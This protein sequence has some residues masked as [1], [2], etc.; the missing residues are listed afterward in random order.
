ML[1]SVLGL[2]LMFFL[3][4]FLLQRLLFGRQNLGERMALSVGFSI[5]VSILTGL[6]LS[7]L[8][9]LTQTNTLL[10]LG[11]ISIVLYATAKRKARGKETTS[12]VNTYDLAK[13]AVVAG[14]LAFIFMLV[15][16]VHYGYTG[17]YQ[18]PHRM[19]NYIE[20]VD[21]QY[22]FPLHADEWTH[23]AQAIDTIENR[24]VSFKNPYFSQDFNYTQTG[25]L[26]PGFHVF[27]A[28]F[29]VLSGVDRVFGYQYLP[30][31]FA[32]ISALMLFMLAR[33]LSG[34]F[35][36]GIFSML[37]YA[38]LRSNVNIMGLWFFI[39]F[40]LNITV[41]YLFYYCLVS[42]LE[43]RKW[44]VALFLVTLTGFSIHASFMLMTIAIAFIYVTVV[45]R[46]FI[47][48]NKK[49]ALLL[50]VPVVLFFLGVFALKNMNLPE[51]LDYL[52]ERITFR[53]YNKIYNVHYSL[54]EFYG[55]AATILAFWGIIRSLKERRNT[56]LVIWAVLGLALWGLFAITDLNFVIRHQRQ[57]YFTL[58]GL[59]PLSAIG[60]HHI[61]SWIKEKAGKT[62]KL[63]GK[64]IPNTTALL[65]AAAVFYATF[66]GYYTIKEKDYV[67]YHFIG[68]EEYNALNFVKEKYGSDNTIITDSLLSTAVYPISGS[69]VLGIEASNLGQGNKWVFEH[70]AA[71]DCNAKRYYMDRFNSTL[72]ITKFKVDCLGVNLAYQ[73][74]GT[75]V[76][77]REK[78]KKT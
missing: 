66:Q 42:S 22:P 12:K 62:I 39:P 5:V 65:L 33:K 44:F 60:L 48:K 4:G 67:L 6:M 68:W 38:S 31:L 54:I 64:V 15:F 71:R 32:C 18:D 14:V 19:P 8:K 46:D 78:P 61:T 9:Q 37:F 2:L 25:F 11:F 47:T 77:V 43:D 7:S 41:I 27:L 13:T 20:G 57:V 51:T 40:V 63:E 49:I 72:L 75:Y 50:A 28:E 10:T 45:K 74:D 35:A 34:S 73:K 3:P 30:A 29:F 52:I 26:E 56:I 36:V 69:K 58:I 76:Y 16:K 23:L 55:L 21:V 17:L 24:G 1:A 70:V 53:E 59:A